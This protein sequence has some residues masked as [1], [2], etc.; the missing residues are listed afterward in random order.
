[1]KR[2]EERVCEKGIMRAL[3]YWNKHKIPNL[4]Q[5]LEWLKEYFQS[6]VQMNKWDS[7]KEYFVSQIALWIE[8]ID[9]KIPNMK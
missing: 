1:M 5:F 7:D 8:F 3:A 4:K 9:I 6:I 2:N